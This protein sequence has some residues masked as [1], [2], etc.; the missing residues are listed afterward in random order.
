MLIYTSVTPLNTL[1]SYT[2]VRHILRGQESMCHGSSRPH[3]TVAQ[4]SVSFEPALRREQHS[5]RFS[6]RSR[7]PLH[8]TVAFASPEPFSGKEDNL[9]PALSQ[10]SRE[11]RRHEHSM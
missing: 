3:S 2:I 7:S 11:L 1:N 9:E 10:R 6:S 4:N 8:R 5:R